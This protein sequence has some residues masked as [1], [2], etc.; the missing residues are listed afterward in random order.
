MVLILLVK[1]LSGGFREGAP[2]ARP[3]YGPKFSQFHA[4]FLQN[5]AKSYVGAPPGGLAPPPMRNPGC[6]PDTY[7]KFL[8]SDGYDTA[9]KTE[10]CR[11]YNKLHIAIVTIEQRRLIC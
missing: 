1:I 11:C 2:G 10:E 8:V 5:L 3:S 9:E 4:V 6:A 7:L